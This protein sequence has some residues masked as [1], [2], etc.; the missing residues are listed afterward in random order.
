MAILRA[1]WGVFDNHALVFLP[2]S[3]SKASHLVSDVLF[4]RLA[5]LP[6]V[7]HGP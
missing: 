6:H 3:R 5:S 2:T 1:G 4:L 7:P